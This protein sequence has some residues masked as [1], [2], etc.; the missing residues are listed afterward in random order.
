MD[1]GF[2]ELDGGLACL[3]AGASR[4]LGADLVGVYLVGSWALRDA[5]E[6]SDVDVLMPV[7]RAPTAAQEADLRALHAELLVPEGHWN[8]GLEGSYPP[9]DELRTLDGLGRRWL[10]VDRGATVMEE[11]TQCNTLEHRWTLRHHGVALAGPPTSAKALA[12]RAIGWNPGDAPP[13]DLSRRRTCSRG[14]PQ[15]S[16]RICE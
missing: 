1:T 6:H 2:T 13:R 5:D 7:A 11:S 10:Y 12:G 16:R 9:V 4:V 8:R 15:A 3:A 14:T